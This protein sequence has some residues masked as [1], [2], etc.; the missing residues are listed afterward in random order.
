[1]IR[2]CAAAGGLDPSELRAVTAAG[3]PTMTHSLLGLPVDGLGEAPFQGVRYQAWCGTPTELGLDLPDTTDV[4][5]LPG[6][7]GHVGADAV[8]AVLATG[9]DECDRPRLL[10]DLGTNTEVVLGSRHGL[11]CASAAAGPAF[12]G[13]VIRY[14][15]RAVPGAIDRVWL[16]HGDLQLGTVGDEPEVGICGSGL[17]DAVAA[18]RQAGVIE[19]SGRMRPAEELAGAP[20]AAGETQRA[21][22]AAP[23][24]CARLT[25]AAPGRAVRLGGTSDRPVYLTAAD[26]RELQLVKASIA[27]AVR[28]L[29]EHSGTR[30]DEVEAVL[31]A[32]A[33]GGTIHQAS[34]RALGLL[35]LPA[36]CPV[37]VVGNAA[38]AGARLALVDERARE[39]AERVARTARTLELAL[40]PAYHATFV[41]SLAFPVADDVA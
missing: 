5:L 25:E 37:E 3:N 4:L 27:A 31:V 10:I 39:R 26:V 16:A 21:R 24:L 33:F 2:E 41:D 17:I 8:A 13:S 12:E 29:L 22:A 35:P 40:E 20:A 15:M 1:L 19:P 18:L 32:G 14:G 30:P 7:A 6:V 38:G 28:M 34:A 23:A 36:A 9:L 11:L